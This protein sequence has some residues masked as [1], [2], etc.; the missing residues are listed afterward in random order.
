MPTNEDLFAQ[1]DSL[2]QEQNAGV[3]IEFLIAHFHETK[4][5]PQLFEA[6]KLRVRNQLGLPLLYSDQSR[7]IDD[8]TQRKLEQGL[9][10]A[11]KDVGELL[12][13]DGQLQQGWMYL[14]PVGD[15]IF[16]RELIE[17]V[18]VTED[19]RDDLIQIALYQGAA[20]EAGYRLLLE[21]Q[22]TCNAITTFDTHNTQFDRPI[23]AKLAVLLVD[24]IYYELV[25]N[26]RRHIEKDKPGI[27]EEHEVLSLGELIR[28]RLWLTEDG[29]HHIDTT[30]LASVMRIGRIVDIS[31]TLQK[32][33][34]LAEYGQRL[35]SDFKYAS[36]APF[37][38]T[39]DD[40]LLFY[41]A[42]TGIEVDAA[43]QH[44]EKKAESIDRETQG[45]VGIETL[46]D[47]LARTGHRTHAIDVAVE[48]LLGHHDQVGI[49]PNVFEIARE[50]SELQQLMNHY[51]DDG[52]L[53]SYS[54]AMMKKMKFET[55]KDSSV[56]E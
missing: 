31:A 34:E 28:D 9:L 6:M 43:I 54:I 10:D 3:A 29:G 37:E 4:E 46:I 7:E 44:F 26:V 52:D 20:P 45:S 15:R 36:S 8:A 14:Q 48:T 51:R 50:G 5:F 39:Y 11:C 32:L 16:V 25:S 40:H 49:A 47:L 35:H 38:D 19:N 27:L 2:T 17:S 23:Q 12:I 41:R 21:S 30:H 24:Q 42:L 13:K 1:L 22:G 33:T 55:K 18:T 53:L 56:S